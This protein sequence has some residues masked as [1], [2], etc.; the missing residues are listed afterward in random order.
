MEVGGV[1]DDMH[2]TAQT[3]GGHS[4]TTGSQADAILN[5]ATAMPPSV[6]IGP[7]AN[8]MRAFASELHAAMSAVSA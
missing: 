2:R 6:C 8:R 7:A 5:A 1:V 4:R 3:W